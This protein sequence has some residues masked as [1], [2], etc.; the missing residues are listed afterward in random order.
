MTTSQTLQVN[1]QLR[2]LA[3]APGTTLL[4]VLRTE[5]GLMATRF[6]CGEE[7]CGACVVLADG[8]PIYACTR[9]ADSLAGVSVVTLEGLAVGGQPHPLQQAFI[10]EQA[11]Q[12]GYCLSGILM[13]ATALLDHNPKPTRA[14]ITA[15]LDKH[16]CRCGAHARIIRA[17]ERAAEAMATRVH[18]S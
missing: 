11:G 18:P 2:P 7:S 5:Y 4:D 17:V 12:C 13:S 8:K 6:G 15:A 16:L 9:A 1:G 10:A 14:E 3:V